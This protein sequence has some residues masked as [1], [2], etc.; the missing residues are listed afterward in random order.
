MADDAPPMM[1]RLPPAAG[2]LTRRQRLALASETPLSA[3]AVMA[4]ADEEFTMAFFQAHG[5]RASHLRVAK[6]NPLQLKARGVASARDLRALEFNALDLGDPAFCASCIAAHGVD[7]VVNEFLITANDAVAVAGTAAVHQL[8]I[9]TGLLL[10]LCAGAPVEAASVLKLSLP[11]G[12]CLRGV[13]AATLIDCGLRVHHLRA[14]G[15]STE[16]VVAQ[17]CATAQQLEQLGF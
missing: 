1:P 4:M 6:L 12:E 16:A 9:G 15:Y 11:R 2:A 17:T 8:N 3:D 5:V 10:L 7:E 14:A 13:A